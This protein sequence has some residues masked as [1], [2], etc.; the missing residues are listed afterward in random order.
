MPEGKR[1][2]VASLGMAREQR[3]PFCPG[4]R[5]WHAVLRG[6][7]KG[8]EWTPQKVSRSGYISTTVDPEAD[9]DDPDGNECDG[10]RCDPGHPEASKMGYDPG[11]R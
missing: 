10:I 5:Y 2:R 6:I 4:D 9:G 1:E 3:A 7:S 8:Q 11:S